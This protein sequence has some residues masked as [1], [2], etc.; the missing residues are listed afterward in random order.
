[1]P[2][3]P[4]KLESY[5]FNLPQELIA[6]YPC[7]PRDQSRLMIVERSS[8]N[9]SE[10][11][12][13]DLLDLLHVGDQLIFNDTKV[14][15][16]R[17]MGKRP[18]GGVAE[19]L[20][21]QSLPNGTWDVMARPGRK[22][23]PGTIITFAPDLSCEVVAVT[24]EGGRLVRFIHQGDFDQ[25]LCRYGRIPLPHYIRGGEADNAD[26]ER[27]QT[28]YAHQPGA[29]AA[30]TAG[31]HF[32]EE[33]IGKLQAK[34]IYQTHITLHVGLGTF[35]PV[36]TEDIR[37][38]HMH[39]ERIIISEKAAG[40]LNQHPIGQQKICVGTTSCRALESVVNQEGKILAGEYESSI[41]IYP[42]YQFRYTKALLTNFHLPQSSLLM[43]VSA[44]A[45]YELM[46]EAYAKAIEQRFRFFSYGD[47]ML[48]L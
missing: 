1:M 36:K 23:S 45:G 48:I 4:Y 8:G 3:D 17:L 40:E 6:Q 43:L 12:F 35:Q 19:L 37:A 7:T 30:P 27:Y 10:M 2:N 31:L 39:S 11:V 13:R 20:L 32:T 46:R 26:T 5:N 16:A 42:G 18:G 25:L 14:I 15:P 34:Q 24:P 29:V 38:H 9:I 44:F 33:M 47:A 21:K 41:F 28:V 22:L